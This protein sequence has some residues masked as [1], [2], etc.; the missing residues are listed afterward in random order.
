MRRGIKLHKHRP[1]LC[2]DGNVFQIT[3]GCM[4]ILVA[5]LDF[6]LLD[7]RGAGLGG[8]SEKSRLWIQQ[9]RG[10][11][12]LFVISRNLTGIWGTEA[13][14]TR[15][16]F[17]MFWL[18]KHKRTCYIIVFIYILLVELA[19]I[20][21]RLCLFKDIIIIFV[22]IALCCCCCCCWANEQE[23]NRTFYLNIHL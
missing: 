20:C 2:R 13:A 19:I 22:D 16:V 15:S 4:E 6:S 18:Q 9:F 5:R 14:L 8:I 10:R 21:F 3:D 7:C 12:F 11:D 23:A 17:M 1:C